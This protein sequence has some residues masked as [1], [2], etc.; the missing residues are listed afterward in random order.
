MIIIYVLKHRGRREEEGLKL[1]RTERIFIMI[2][3]RFN[4]RL[5]VKL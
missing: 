2:S 4:L 5:L 1:E 3:C